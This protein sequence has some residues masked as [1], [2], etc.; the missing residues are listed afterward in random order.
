MRAARALLPVVLAGLLL[1]APPSGRAAEPEGGKV[2]L[3]A[4]AP[5]SFVDVRSLTV[6]AET[7]V[8]QKGLGV[9]VHNN[10]AE[11]QAASIRV[12]GGEE[13]EDPGAQA[14]LSSEPVPLSL[15]PGET[16]EATI[17]LGKGE[18]APTAGTYPLLLVAGGASG[19]VS[20]RELT[21]SAG[22]GVAPKADRGAAL[23]PEANQDVTLVAVNYL[24]SP[25]SGLS[26]LSL[27]AGLLAGVAL[28]VVWG[29]ASRRVRLL[30]FATGVL[31]VT[32]GSV[33][34]FNSRLSAGK[35]FHA[36]ASR[37]LPVAIGSHQG[38][39]GTPSSE[40][41]QL[42]RLAV[43]GER[44]RPQNLSH[45]GSYK[46]PYDLAPE[47]DE[48][49]GGTATVNVR[50]WWPWAVLALALGVLIGYLL[51]RWYQRQR[52]ETKLKL[53]R[54]R[55]AV[56]VA[57]GDEAFGKEAAGT[58]Y[59]GLS[60]ERRLAQRLAEIDA[61][62]EEGDAKAADAI[63]ELDA[64]V[65]RFAR[66]R[67]TMPS[68]LAA[69]QRLEKQVGEE[70]FGVPDGEVELYSQL[71]EALAMR[72]DSADP[73]SD[74]KILENAQKRLDEVRQLA[75]SAAKLHS[76]LVV[77]L[78]GVEKAV[79]DHPTGELADRLKPFALAFRKLGG[80]LLRAPGPDAIKA[81]DAAAR[82]KWTEFSE[83]LQGATAPPPVVRLRNWAAVADA[84]VPPAE[85][86]DVSL[87]T[88]GPPPPGALEGKST[89]D[90]EV[91]APPGESQQA[92]HRDDELMIR[93]VAPSGVGA[94]VTGFELDMGEGTRVDRV[95]VEPHLGPA[96][97]IAARRIEDGGHH[98]L[99]VRAL[100]G[101]EPVETVPIV[102]D[103]KSRVEAIE[104]G[105]ARIDRLMGR[106]AFVLAVGSGLVALYVSDAAWGES[107]DY[108]AAVLWG[109]TAAE[110][111]KLAGAIADRAWPGS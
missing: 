87:E 13:L 88:Q 63:A 99:R 19:P 93:L 90:Y 28:F 106:L 35:S 77:Q 9:L 1:A 34:G 49:G 41:G 2:A 18:P 82:Q 84:Y 108:L 27:A 58:P 57:A 30:I 43:E 54:E 72:V 44:M 48:K 80:E 33:H 66:L 11:K 69:K 74:G 104:E 65:S 7:L 64:Y 5:V 103:P 4:D 17:P 42:A 29:S 95:C 89:V 23:S 25:L 55:L 102:V 76:R 50:D 61:K 6:K 38:T 14:L 85:G 83:L 15:E 111:V 10:S 45:A 39:V 46:G 32:I 21:I 73:D 36:I 26:W 8:K 86:D 60:I 98:E 100:P 59:E 96:E 22:G 52:P 110:G 70:R 16:Q 12:V 75:E 51:R 101:R 92:V 31:L 91:L 40:S 68:I 105:L 56:R 20:R 71:D 79:S 109:G 97:A 62:I 81:V 78:R 3:E 24:P 94:G 107:A 37:P 47:V 67:A 53:R